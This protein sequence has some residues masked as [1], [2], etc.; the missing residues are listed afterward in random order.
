MVRRL[1]ILAMIGVLLCG[2][3][4]RTAWAAEESTCFSKTGQCIRGRI[5]QFWEQ[6][7]GLAVFGYPLSAAHQEFN[8]ELQR[9]LEVQWFERNRLEVHPELQAPY[10]VLLG[11]LGDD[12]MR[13]Q[14]RN[15]GQGPRGAKGQP[16]CLWFEETGHTVCN[17]GTEQGFKRFWESQGI[18]DPGLDAYA[19]SLA[20]F[21]YPLTEPRAETNTS[22][23]T[24][25]TQWFERA[26][27][28]WHP[29]ESAEFRVLLGLLGT[30]LQPTAPVAPPA[31]GIPM[32]GG[33]QELWTLVNELHRSAGCAALR[34]DDRVAAAAQGHADDIASHQRIDHRGTDGAT[35]GER[36]AR[37]RYP[38]RFATESIAVYATPREAVAA[39]MDEPPDGPH[40]LNI[41]SCQYQDAGIGYAVDARGWHWWVMDFANQ[42][43]PTAARLGTKAQSGMSNVD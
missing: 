39:W 25:V 36:L 35:V 21:G 11:R 4:V 19:R 2:P 23:N 24:V 40:R 27:F 9:N 13:Q 30:E 29:D 26:R 42:R 14:H 22:G 12:R 8:R 17:Q 6:Q 31:S 7:G 20:L 41:T 15:W 32:S 3:Q 10:D 33:K 1:A 43:S 28:E 38:V 5:R 16:A 37:Q 34:F 18:Q